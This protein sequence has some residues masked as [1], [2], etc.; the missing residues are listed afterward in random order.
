[1]ATDIKDVWTWESDPQNGFGTDVGRLV[2]P[3]HG[4]AANRPTGREAK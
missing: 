3:R 2:D 1:M 4:A